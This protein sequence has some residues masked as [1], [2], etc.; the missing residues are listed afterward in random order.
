MGAEPLV[1][2]TAAL[3]IAYEAHGDARLVEKLHPIQGGLFR[4]KY[5]RDRR[6]S[7]PMEPVWASAPTRRAAAMVALARASDGVKPA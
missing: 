5:R 1:V 3:A 4:L 7:L 2:R 6:P